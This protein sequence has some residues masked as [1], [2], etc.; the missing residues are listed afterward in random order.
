MGRVGRAESM[1]AIAAAIDAGITHFDVARLYGYGEAES[2]L[3]EAIRGKRDRLVIASKFGLEPT[4]TAG[5]LRG[6]KPLAQKVAGSVPGLR[7][8]LRSVV[9]TETHAADRFSVASARASLERSLRALQTDY[10]DILFLHDCEPEEVTGELITFLDAQIAAG[11]IRAYGAA[12]GFKQIT[13]LCQTYGDKLLCQFGNG[14]CARRAAGLP[15]G[16]RRFIGHSPFFGADRLTALVKAQPERFKLK[17]GRLKSGRGIQS[18]DIHGLML[19]YALSADNI[20]V[21]LCSMLRDEHRRANLAALAHPAFTSD[22]IAEFAAIVAAALPD[23]L[24]SE[25]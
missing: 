15:R 1:R 10:L 13:R 14:L 11:R 5:A 2:L 4:R 20:A 25:G 22:E 18:A 19:G 17:S 12:T 6:L 3:G 21:V 23:L 8:A 7:G 16:Q 9:G 24:P